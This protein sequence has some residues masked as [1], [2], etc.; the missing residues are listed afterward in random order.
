MK[1]TKNIKDVAKLAGVSQASVSKFLNS[2]PY[3]SE[4]TKEKIVKA[5]KKLNYKPNAIARSLVKRKSNC[6]GLII[7]DITNPFYAG[8]VK[9]MENYINSNNTFFGNK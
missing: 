9:S 5:I 4:K 8:I 2:K 1:N 6:I 3:V 7:R